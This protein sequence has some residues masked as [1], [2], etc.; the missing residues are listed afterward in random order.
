[1]PPLTTKKYF[2]SFSFSSIIRSL[3]LVSMLIR[4]A[5][6]FIKEAYNTLSGFA[7]SPLLSVTPAAVNKNAP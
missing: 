6:P 5:R 2:S 1:M 3:K 4:L 7:A